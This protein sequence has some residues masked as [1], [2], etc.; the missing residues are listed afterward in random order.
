VLPEFPAPRKFSELDGK[1]FLICV[2][3]AKCATSWVHHYLAALP[4]VTVS[5]LKE[6]HFFDM[7]YASLSLGDMDDVAIKRV[8]F[9]LQ[10]K[11]DLV[12]YLQLN[13]DFQASV[14]RMQMVYDDNAYFGHFA[15]LCTPETRLFCDITPGY[16]VIGPDGFEFV[17]SFCATQDIRLKLLFLMRDPVDRL[18]SQLRHLQQLNPEARL[19]ERWAEAID[20]PRICA[21]SDYRGIVTDLDEIFSASDIL[22][23]FYEDLFTE[24]SLRRLCDFAG[25][26]FHAGQ[27]E[28]RRNRTSYERDLPRD[29]CASFMTL[30]APQYEFCHRRFGLQVPASW[31][32]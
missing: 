24:T 31:R 17:N 25:I 21:R 16:S 9:H 14:D 23:L 18:W 29:A 30:L 22:Y 32:A 4:G 11:G 28:E 6:L 27:V 7:K 19:A 3:A 15:R 12:E 20:S 10:R 5:P 26:R 2:G 8:G 13:A 1:T